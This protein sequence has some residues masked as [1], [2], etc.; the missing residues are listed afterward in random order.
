[1]VQKGPERTRDRSRTRTDCKGKAVQRAFFCPPYEQLFAI[2]TR[3]YPYSKLQALSIDFVD[4]QTWQNT[5]IYRFAVRTYWHGKNSDQFVQSFARGLSVIRCF[6]PNSREMTLTQIAE[7]TN[8]SRAG[9]R[10]ILCTLKN[11]GYVGAD[12]RYFSLTPRILDLGILSVIF[13]FL[14]FCPADHG[15][16]GCKGA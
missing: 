13:A 7:R 12:G 3:Q 9:A 16:H 15:E 5:C 6:G 8:L 4:P 14:G 1:M 11:L 10:R 2:R